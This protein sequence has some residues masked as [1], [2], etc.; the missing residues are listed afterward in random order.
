M[1]DLVEDLYDYL[2][3][4]LKHNLQYTV[5]RLNKRKAPSAVL[6]WCFLHCFSWLRKQSNHIVHTEEWKRLL[7]TKF[8][9]TRK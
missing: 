3:F 6:G 5:T 2:F 7:V 9:V 1:F 4:Q 8:S